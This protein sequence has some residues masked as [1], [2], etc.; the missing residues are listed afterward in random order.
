MESFVVA[1][2]PNNF[3]DKERSKLERGWAEQLSPEQVKLRRDRRQFPFLRTGIFVARLT[4]GGSLG[5][6]RGIAIRTKSGDMLFEALMPDA[7][8]LPVPGT[9]PPRQQSN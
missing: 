9:D 4:L 7:H 8:G 2:R 6:A 3:S 5:A 1:Y